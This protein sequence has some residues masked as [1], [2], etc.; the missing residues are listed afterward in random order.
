AHTST[1]FE[2]F[3]G[4]A[5]WGNDYTTVRVDTRVARL[6]STTQADPWPGGAGNPKPA[7]G[8]GNPIGGVYGVDKR[9]GDGCFGAVANQFGEGECAATVKS[10]TDYM[11]SPAAD[12]PASRGLYHQSNIGMIR[13]HCLVTG[14]P[15]CPT[16][17][18]DF[19]ILTKYVN[20][21]LWAEGLIRTNQ[22]LALAAT[23]INNS[24]VTRGGL[25]PVTA[26]DLATGLLKALYYEWHV[27][28]LNIQPDHLW[29]GRR[30]SKTNLIAAPPNPYA[31]GQQLY[32][33]EGSYVWN[34]LWGNTPRS[35]PIPAKDL[36]LLALEIYSFGGPNDPLGCGG[37]D[38]K[39]ACSASEGTSGKV[40]NVREIYQDLLNTLP[41]PG[42][43]PRR[44]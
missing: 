41:K 29:N 31:T 15:D 19:P 32:E 25:P 27:E 3:D 10:G 40:R 18:G 13:Y 4:V 30:L 24:R 43:K 17:A 7:D 38:P 20:D 35:M 12:F 8:A 36:S 14:F 9:M 39:P 28:L 23:L 1:N 6:L 34:S 44:F 5:Q 16:G 26:A 22:N 21:L 42:S 33:P 37:P 2:F 11:W